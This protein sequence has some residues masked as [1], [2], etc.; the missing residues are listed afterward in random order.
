MKRGGMSQKDALNPNLHPQPKTPSD[1]SGH[2]FAA[3][4]KPTQQPFASMNES[5]NRQCS[6]T[7]QSDTATL[8]VGPSLASGCLSL[9]HSDA[10]QISLTM[11]P[12][13]QSDATRTL[14]GESM[15]G[16]G[17][18]P[19]ES[20]TTLTRLDSFDQAAAF[21]SPRRPHD[22]RYLSVPPPRASSRFRQ[23][24]LEPY[25]TSRQNSCPPARP[26]P[27]QT[28]SIVAQQDPGLGLLL[29]L[30]PEAR[31]MHLRGRWGRRPSSQPAA[32]TFPHCQA[33]SSSIPYDQQRSESDSAAPT[34]PSLLSPESSATPSTESDTFTPSL[35]SLLEGYFGKQDTRQHVPTTPSSC[36]AVESP[37]D[38]QTARPDQ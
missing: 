19:N 2:H 27:S 24:S 22:S 6:T 3:P 13:S 28:D 10:T 34:T 15:V 17:S 29:A 14:V 7:Q 33:S 37:P 9:P 12:P 5:I 36:N 23:Q 30:P 11:T 18:L 32:P 8:A 25:S 1:V 4:L 35:G 20:R 26:R 38:P 16:A 21:S 31:E